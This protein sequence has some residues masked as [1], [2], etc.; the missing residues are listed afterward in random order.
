[1]TIVE[2][3]KSFNQ[4]IQS[5][6]AVDKDLQNL[7]GIK[8]YDFIQEMPLLKE[9]F[10]R[11]VEYLQRLSRD[12]A[13]KENQEKLFGVISDIL[14]LVTRKDIEEIQKQWNNA[15]Y[16]S[17]KKEKKDALEL[18]ELYDALLKKENYYLLGDHGY[19]DIDDISCYVGISCVRKQYV[20]AERMLQFIFNFLSEKDNKELQKKSTALAEKYNKL[21]YKFNEQIYLI[22][23][24]IDV[25]EFEDLQIMCAQIHPRPGQEMWNLMGYGLS[26]RKIENIKKIC[27][28]V[29]SD[30]IEFTEKNEVATFVAGI[31]HER[32]ANNKPTFSHEEMLNAMKER[33][34]KMKN[35]DVEKMLEDYKKGNFVMQEEYVSTEK[36]VYSISVKDREIRVN[37]YLISRPHAVGSNFEFFEYVR[38]QASHTKI[39]RKNLPSK[40]EQLSIKEQIKNKSFIKILNG[41]GFK[42]EILKAYFYNRAKDTLT[43][44]GDKIEKDDLE[45]AGVNIPLFLK[46][47]DLAHTKNSPK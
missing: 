37:T 39:E 16:H 8:L 41:L 2:K 40:F 13:F 25:K 30:L 27:D 19:H 45:K 32:K 28:T 5:A 7:I 15:L 12:N 4:K 34:Q 43:Y 18:P 20:T 47:L 6:V 3:L 38:S 46:E 23:L 1:M 36:N 33:L 11:R 31:E 17:L 29:I 42:G 9:E 26:N 44:K 14:H 21:W 10:E 24:K 35:E 22:T